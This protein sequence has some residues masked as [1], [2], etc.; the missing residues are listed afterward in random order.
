MKKTL[1]LMLCF[2]GLFALFHVSEARG[3]CPTRET[4][5]CVRS[6]NQCC[7]SRDCPGS[8]LCCRE[9]CG[10]KCKRM[11]PRRTDGVEVFFDSRC[12]IDEY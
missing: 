6:I 1:F 11:Y 10:N 2:L 5:V 4:V 12:K 7:S 8:D 9:N 3:Y